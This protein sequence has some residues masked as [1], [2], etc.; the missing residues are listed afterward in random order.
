[1][2]AAVEV[3]L[4]LT[5]AMRSRNWVSLGP[6][7]CEGR[8]RSQASG[9]LGPE[10]DSGFRPGRAFAAHSSQLG[11]DLLQTEPFAGAEWGGGAVVSQPQA[12]SR[13]ELRAGPSIPDIWGDS[14]CFPMPHHL[15]KTLGVPS[16]SHWREEDR[17]G[18]GEGRGVDL[19]SGPSLCPS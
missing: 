12:K 2:W 16:S 8:R 3:P 10:G 5:L 15:G 13:A 19:E 17:F 7:G 6:V 9:C 14:R 4:G 18:A 11:N 1:M